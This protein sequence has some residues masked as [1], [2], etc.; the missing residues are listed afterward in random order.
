MLFKTFSAAVFGIDAYLVE[1]EVDISAGNPNFM[2]VGLPDAAVRESRERIKS[3]IKNCGHDFPFQNITVNL[4]PADVKKEG[5]G[6]DLAMALGIL[7]TTGVLLKTDLRNYLFLGELSLDGSLRPVKGA[8]SIASLARQKRIPKLVLPVENAREAAVVQDVAVY[9]LRS[10]PEVLDFINETREFAPAR[11]NVGEMLAQSSQYLVD[12]CEVKG[13]LHAKRAIEVATAGGHNILM[14]GP[15]GAGKTMLAKRIPTILPPLTFDEAIQTTK[16]HSVAGALDPG[17]GLVGTR[18]FRAP[19]HTISDAGLIGGGA[20]PRPGEV[21]LAHNGLLFL[22]ELPEFQRNVLEVLRQPLEDGTVTIARA[23][24]SLTFPA[25]FMLAS[26]M[27]PCPCGFFNDSSRQCTCT[28]PLIQRYISKISGPLLDRID[29]HIDMPA[30]KYR[31]LRDDSGGESSE[32]IRRRVIKARQRQLARYQGE[33]IYSNAQ[34][35]P[36]QIHKYCA[37]SA[38]CERLLESAVNRLGLSARAH[39]RIL[40]VART[41]A[42]LAE[43]SSISTDHISQA[44]QYRS[45]DRNYWA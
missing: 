26:A 33:K 10:L 43:S 38:E 31:E 27:N 29:I 19:H 23:S 25:R 39:D 30:V 3:A 15:P 6:F 40:K 24:M 34:M 5:S 18:P 22:D 35:S 45:L 20:V 32:E 14:I 28:P 42:D 16:I 44:I 12:F 21:S 41:I 8:L 13:Q 9:G 36:R 2:T 7:G 1:A 11:V 4:A 17:A 37:I